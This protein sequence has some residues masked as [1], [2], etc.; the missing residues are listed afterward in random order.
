MFWILL[1]SRDGR[2]WVAA[3]NGKPVAMP[4]PQPIEV[5]DFRWRRLVNPPE[6]SGSGVFFYDLTDD[7]LTRAPA[8]PL[9]WRTLVAEARAQQ[10]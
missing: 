5:Q 1:F 2:V 8:S 6:S 4:A 9:D 3:E 10:S 7:S